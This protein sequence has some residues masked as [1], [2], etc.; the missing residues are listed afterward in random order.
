MK[1]FVKKLVF[2]SALLLSGCSRDYAPLFEFEDTPIDTGYSLT[3]DSYMNIDAKDDESVYAGMQELEF[4]EVE[5]GIKVKSKAHLGE[6][7]VYI[8]TY[9]NDKNIYV[10]SDKEFF[11]NDSVE[12]YLDPNPA[13]SRSNEFLNGSLRVRTD[14]VQVRINPLGEY[15][16]W[17]GRRI[18]G[19]YAYPWAKG[20][21]KVKVATKVDGTI[22]A[23]NGATGYSVEAFIPYEAMELDAKPKRIGLMVAFNNVDNR[24]DTTRKWFT[25]KGMSHDR[26]TSYAP[27]TSSGFE[28]NKVEPVKAL[29]A[30]Y[31][32]EYYALNNEINLYEVNANNEN[33]VLR[34]SFKFKVG[35]DGLY[36]IAKVK[37]KVRSYVSDVIF[38]N[39]GIELV[40]DARGNKSPDFYA[41]GLFRFSFDN[42]L[43]TQSDRMTNGHF[44]Y[45]PFFAPTNI[46]TAVESVTQGGIY[47]Y[48]YE[49]TYEVMIPYSVMGLEGSVT[50]LDVAFA[51]KSPNETA[52]IL[53]R[54]DGGGNM[55]GQDWLW[56]D[57]H[58]PRNPAEF[59][60]VR[61]NETYPGKYI[62]YPFIEWE[63]WDALTLNSDAPL[64]YN[65][66]GKAAEDGLYI[67][68]VQ[69]V[70]Y[71]KV[72]HAQW[73]WVNNPHIEMEVWHKNIGWGMGGTYFAFFIDGS[74]YLN[75]NTNIQDVKS[76]VKVGEN[77]ESAT[78]KYTI[79]YEIHI[80]FN[81]NPSGGPTG[82]A[83]IMSYTPHESLA[84]YENASMIIKDEGA[85][86]QR[87][88]WTDQATATKFAITGAIEKV[89]DFTYPVWKAWSECLVRSDSPSRYD[90]RG[91]A[92]NNGL[93]FNFIQN[94]NNYTHGSV[95]GNWLTSTH[96]ELEI[97]QGDIGWGWGGTYLAFFLDGSYYL[98][99]S[100]GMKNVYC[101]VT[102]QDN[103]VAAPYRYTINYEVHL[104]FD[105]NLGSGDGPYA[106]VQF[107]SSTPGE[108][109]AGYENSKIITKDGNRNLWTDN[110]NS[111]E[112]RWN[113]I[114]NKDRG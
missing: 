67:H 30:N 76:R 47:N 48:K 62:D 98:N 61:E 73:D 77:G 34:A 87:V 59:F 52:Y 14:N 4:T 83:Q 29:T 2:I 41:D 35:A 95:G 57:G 70:N 21:F 104:N 112:F 8:Y 56:V 79:S 101:K 5:S 102:V 15:E 16:T 111:V 27:V 93:Y 40:V 75:N 81:N 106:Y 78:Y 38:E 42:A 84:G 22:N 69:Y 97:W 108:G 13:Y 103:G 54:K 39:D 85:G 100:A 114:V 46:K 74:Y 51:V 31:N 96:L 17:Y 45:V 60:V 89:H 86:H 7:G 92:A 99:N 9:V 63:S 72:G 68:V 53:N 66:Q 64:R 50:H 32:D 107:M 36:A 43:G 33:P 94:V 24:Q 82:L 6:E 25:C 26:L 18:G 10:L 90:Y 11:Q 58:Y 1:R 65:Y 19:Q 105:N 113:G 71:Y 28:I 44:D 80:K 20:F 23:Q 88:L 91:Y 12:Y 55:E 109:S 49:Y 37:D 110:A 3:Q